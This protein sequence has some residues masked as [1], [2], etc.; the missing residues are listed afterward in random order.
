[1]S[2]ASVGPR[3]PAR[4]IQHPEVRVNVIHR[5][6]RDHGERHHA[7]LGLN[8]MVVGFNAPECRGALTGRREGVEIRTYRV[9]YQLTETSS[10]RSSLEAIRTEETIGEVSAAA[11]LPPRD[12]RRLLRQRHRPA[13][14]ERSDRP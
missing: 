8:A 6:G 11:R 14:R 2:S 10:R 4:Q 12:D 5:R 9:I 7:R 13:Q 1:M 3:S